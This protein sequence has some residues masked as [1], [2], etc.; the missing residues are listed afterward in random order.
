MA[1]LRGTHGGTEA[2]R[3]RR[4][5]AGT[6]PPRLVLGERGLSRAKSG[7]DGGGLDEN[8]SGAL[9]AA[10][11]ES[12]AERIVA[13]ELTRLGWVEEELARRHQRDPDK[14]AIAAR[15]RP[16]TTLTIKEIALRPHLG[17]PG[18]AA[19]R[20]HHYLAANR[21]PAAAQGGDAE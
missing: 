11:A 2:G 8:H 9:R 10:T 3:N 4:R 15:L 21:H 12:M 6:V 5:A 17:K 1:G 13:A 14:L 16:E 18:R 19:V 7:V 20:L